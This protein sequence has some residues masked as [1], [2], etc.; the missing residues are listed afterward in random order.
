VTG[1]VANL[2]EKIGKLFGGKKLDESYNLPGAGSASPINTSPGITNAINYSQPTYLPP[3]PTSDG[4]DPNY[5]GPPQLGYG[6]SGTLKFGGFYGEEYLPILQG[7]AGV[8]TYDEMFRSDSQVYTSTMRTFNKIKN[9]KFSVKASSK[10]PEAKLRAEKLKYCL[11]DSPNKVWHDNLNDILSFLI[12][13]FSVLEP[14]FRQEDNKKFGNIWCVNSYGWRSPKTIW[15]WYLKGDDLHSLRQISWG[16]DFK[17]VDIPGTAYVGITRPDGTKEKVPYSELIVFTHLRFGNNLEGISPLRPMY[18]PYLIKD[19]MNKINIVGAENNAR[20][21][22]VFSVAD[23]FLGTDKDKQLD[24]INLQAVQSNMPMV[25]ISKESMDFKFYETRYQSAALLDSIQSFDQ[26]I[27]KVTQ[28]ESSELGLS[29]HGSHSMGKSK[30]AGHDESVKPIADYICQKLG[31]L[32]KFL[33]IVNDG[34]QEEYC[35]VVV[36]GID[37]KPTLEDA[38]K[39]QVLATIYPTVFQSPEIVEYMSEHFDLPIIAPNS[40]PAPDKASTPAPAPAPAPDPA[41][42]NRMPQIKT[43]EHEHS[44]KQFAEFIPRRAL[45]DWEKKVS[46]AEIDDNLKTLDKNYV[47]AVRNSIKNFLLPKYEAGLRA[48][49]KNSRNRHKDVL[50]VEFGKKTK[51]REIIKSLITD[52]AK[53]GEDSATVE[54][55]G[56]MASGTVFAEKIGA[57][58]WV[59]ANADFATD[60]LYSDLTK[61]AQTQALSSIDDG[62]SDD[63]IIYDT[64][65]A[66]DDFIE[67]DAVLGAGIIINKAFNAGRY[68]AFDD[69]SDE[70]QGFQYSALLDDATCDLCEA[71]D[72]KT[73]A[74]DDP[75]S[76]EYNP[77]LHAQCRCIIVPI[78]IND[79]KPKEWDGLDTAVDDSD[80]PA[81]LKKLKTLS[82]RA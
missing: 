82:E 67:K 76:D 32:A 49:L 74:A 71:L 18:R 31:Q 39:W 20:G 52:A 65:A 48:A 45:T 50:S 27:A 42:T 70:I 15:Q 8:Q 61:K 9:A 59:S 34:E 10:T 28:T 40:T 58:G 26:D 23:Q 22:R 51:V 36:E 53:K 72:G 3:L 2:F 73:F 35:T 60:T 80:D 21:L 4:N 66:V 63:E 54:I 13:S 44:H 38:Q 11:F 12:Y 14:T 64:T 5:N 56:K 62:R 16:D 43:H 41:P 68:A 69:M 17:Y 55:R 6:T 37:S 19:K 7:R 33:E 1:N 30:D 24:N 77:P 78:T 75:D 79:P 25:K 47:N 46:F 29:K 57:F 81:K